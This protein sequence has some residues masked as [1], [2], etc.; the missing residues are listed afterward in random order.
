MKE[1]SVGQNRNM[2]IFFSSIPLI[3]FWP[4][5]FISWLPPPVRSWAPVWDRGWELLMCCLSADISKM[6]LFSSLLFQDLFVEDHI[7]FACFVLLI[8]LLLLCC[9]FTMDGLYRQSWFPEKASSRFGEIL[10]L[11]LWRH[12]EVI[13]WGFERE[14]STT[15]ERLLWDVAQTVMFA[16]GWIVITSWRK[17]TWSHLLF[18]QVKAAVPQCRNTVTNKS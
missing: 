5:R 18:K 16:S 2:P 12:H 4:C 13:V 1:F 7:Y 17:E 8:C 10:W 14:V 6:W 3:F 15:V 9:V 11:L